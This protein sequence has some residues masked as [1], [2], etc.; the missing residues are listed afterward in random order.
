MSLLL[1]KANSQLKIILS[2]SKDYKS[3]FF[4]ILTQ[5]FFLNI[6][7]INVIKLI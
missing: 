2:S 5:V 4:I 3:L 1:L 6:I 7:K